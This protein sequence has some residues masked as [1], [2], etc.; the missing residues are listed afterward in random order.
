[1][2]KVGVLRARFS[3]FSGRH[4]LNAQIHRNGWFA[5]AAVVGG[6]ATWARRRNG[7]Y[8]VVLVDINT[9]ERVAEFFSVSLYDV[10]S[11]LR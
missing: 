10:V 1:M 9:E 2:D 4:G 5:S 11:E 3:N 8:D 7:V 6:R